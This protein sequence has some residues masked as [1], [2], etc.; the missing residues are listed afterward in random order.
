MLQSTG[1]QRV[2]H[3]L[4]TEKQPYIAWNSTLYSVMVYTGK[5]LKK[6]WCMYNLFPFL[7]SW[8]QCNIVNQLNLFKKIKNF[9]KLKNEIFK[10]YITITRKSKYTSFKF[11]HIP[12][13]CSIKKKHF[14][15]NQVT[16][17]C[18]Y[19]WSLSNILETSTRL[20][21]CNLHI[22]S[23]FPRRKTKLNSLCRNLLQHSGN[24]KSDT[25][26]L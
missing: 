19:F 4:V 13:V 11:S 3:D 22:S 21:K 17:F 10:K 23:T 1:S 20:N 7:Y 5:N 16:K 6:N 25:S 12:C 2:R 8:N 15:T 18:K 9:F 14:V 24:K 26:H